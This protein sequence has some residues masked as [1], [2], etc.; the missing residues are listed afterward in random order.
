L[1]GLNPDFYIHVSVTVLYIPRIGPHIF[2][3]ADRSWEYINHLKTH[4]CGNWDC[5]RAVPFLGICVSNFRFCVFAGYSLLF[6]IL[7][8]YLFYVNNT[9]L[10]N[11]DSGIDY[12]LPFL[13]FFNFLLTPHWDHITVLY[14]RHPF[15]ILIAVAQRRAPNF[16][17]F[18]VPDWGGYIIDSG[19]GCN[20][21]LSAR[22]HRL[23][24][25]YDNPMPEST[26][27]KRHENQVS[28]DGWLCKYF[29]TSAGNSISSQLG[30]S[31]QGYR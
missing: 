12:I 31:C 28:Y 2:L 9:P 7:Y 4:E 14:R 18:L 19:I 27:E 10:F 21:Y 24:G 16:A 13:L 1:R 11:P 25:R 22:L 23:A 8:V 6:P 5:G 15:F 17:I 30:S 3:Q 29:I 20:K 26:T